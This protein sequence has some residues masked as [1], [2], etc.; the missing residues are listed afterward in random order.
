M[1]TFQFKQFAVQQDACAMKVG[2]DAVLLGAWAKFAPNALRVLDIG[3]GTGVLALMAAQRHPMMHIHALEPEEAAAEQAEQN[4]LRS[5]FS[6][7]LLLYPYTAQEYIGHCLAPYDAIIC[8]PPYFDPSRFLT[9]ADSARQ[10]ARAGVRLSFAELL[11]CCAQFLKPDSGEAFFIIPY[12]EQEAFINAAIDNG[13]YLA[14]RTRVRPYA[15]KNPTRLLLHLARTL[16]TPH[17]D[18]LLLHSETVD[19][20][21][22]ARPYSDEYRRLLADF[23]TVF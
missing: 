14:R 11:Q 19:T 17:N 4:F 7:R 18:E 21:R 12:S 1:S 22:N 10:I 16:Q 2:T 8:N 15:G 23:L 20:E 3:T 5:P 13:F 6:D 9:A